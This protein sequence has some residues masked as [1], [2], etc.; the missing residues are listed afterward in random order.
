MPNW[1]AEDKANGNLPVAHLKTL[2][3]DEL[4][5]VV[6]AQMPRLTMEEL[7]SLDL[8]D[9]VFG[10]QRE[11][12]FKEAVGARRREL[13]QER[14]SLSARLKLLRRRVERIRQ[15]GD[16]RAAAAEIAGWLEREELAPVEE[17]LAAIAAQ[18]ERL[19]ASAA[20]RGAGAAASA[21]E[22]DDADEEEVGGDVDIAEVPP[23][24]GART[25]DQLRHLQR[26]LRAELETVTEELAALARE[27]AEER[28]AAGR[29]GRQAKQESLRRQEARAELEARAGEIRWQLAQLPGLIGQRMQA[30]LH[31][32]RVALEAQRAEISARLAALSAQPPEA[33]VAAY[34]AAREAEIAAMSARIPEIERELQRLPEI[35]ETVYPWLQTKYDRFIRKHM[36]GFFLPG[37]DK[38]DL[39]QIAALGFAKATKDYNYQRQ[40][41]FI[42]FAALC[43]RR[44][45]I[46]A[47]KNARREKH[48]ALNGYTSFDA[49]VG[50]D[51]DRT[52][53]DFITYRTSQETLTPEDKVILDEEIRATIAFLR[54][55]LSPTEYEVFSEWASGKSYEEIRREKGWSSV[56]KID[57]ALQRARK[58]IP[59]PEILLSM[60]L[61]ARAQSRKR[62]GGS[63]S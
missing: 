4:V 1:S 7:Q 39:Y 60:E 5:A 35:T 49:M 56:K 38:G 41:S 30:Q 24:D 21:P 33:V 62:T 55:R 17:R 51:G 61:G 18:M 47:I 14:D 32:E 10:A 23:A 45:I 59:D 58:K 22:V 46:T 11:L 34:I 3:T 13:R 8:E 29:S 9:L 2:S 19:E 31:E 28:G 40:T 50:A 26:A 25:V 52:L 54:E 53:G 20:A 36:S 48:A 43:I 37:G 16:S 6:E 57:N 12:R 63:A 44:N 42:S 15:I 27:A